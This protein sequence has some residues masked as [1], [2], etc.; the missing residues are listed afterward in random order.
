MRTPASRVHPVKATPETPAAELRVHT[1]TPTRWA[2]LLDCGTPIAAALALLLAGRGAAFPPPGPFALFAGLAA[3][4]EWV[5]IPLTYGGYQTFG[6]LVTLPLVVMLGPVPAALAAA[7]GNAIGSG[8]LRRRPAAMVAF[9]AGQRTLSILL[10]GCVW[11]TLLEGRPVFGRPALAPPGQSAL[12]AF[13]GIILT[14]ALATTVLVSTRVSVR[15][16]QPFWAVLCANAPWQGL[17]HLVLGASGLL[18]ALLALGRLHEADIVLPIPL[19]TGTFVLLLYMGR[20][21]VAQE[22]R[23]LHGAVADLLQTLDLAEVLNRLADRLQRLADP[24]LIWVA[25]RGPDGAYEIPLAR[26]IA[27]DALLPLAAGA[28]AEGADAWALEHRRPLRIADYERHARRRPEIRHVCG[29]G[30]VRAALIVPLLA[31]GEPLG[32]VTLTKGIPDFFTP[33]QERIVTTLAAQAALAVNNA[34]LYEAAQRNLARVEAVQ[35]LARIAASGEDLA[36]VQQTVIDLAVKVLGADRGVLAVYDEERRALTGAAFHNVP[37]EEAAAWRTAVPGDHWRTYA[38]ARAIREMQPVPIHDRRDLPGAPPELPPGA[39]RSVLAVPMSVQGRPLGTVAVGRTDLHTWTAPEIDLLQALASEGA[40]AI[41]NARLSRSTTEQLQRIWALEAISERINSQHD[42]HAVFELIAESAREVLG[43][44]RCGI[45]L[46]GEELGIVHTFARG[47]PDDYLRAVAERIRR[48]QSLANAVMRQRGPVVIPDAGGDPRTQQDWAGKIG[49]RTVATFPLI[50]RGSAIGI[51]ALYHDAV[52]PYGPDELALGAA[53]AN[54]AAIAVQNTRL[55]QEAE[56]RAH[57]LGL[58]NRIVT[59]VARLLRPEDLYET[60]VEEL[61]TTLGYPFVSLLVAEGDR[62]RVAAYRGYIDHEET[63]PYTRGVVGRVARTR[64]AVLVEDVSRDPDY[65]AADPRVTQEACVPIFQEGRLA[66]LLNIEVIEPTLTHADLDLLVTLAGEVRAAMRNAALFAEAQQ[67]RDELQALYECAQALGASLELSTVLQAM[68]SVTCRQ[69]GYD[70]GAILL[71]D[72]S[73]DLAV[74]ATHGAPAPAGR[75]PIGHGAEGRAAYEARPVLVADVSRD[76]PQPSL[77]QAPGATLAVPLFREGR[78][79]GVF[80]VGTTRPG[81]LGER[82]QRTLMMLA[83]Y[84]AVAIENARLYEQARHFAVTDGLTDLLNHRAFR[85]AL[86]QE[87]ERAKRYALPLALIMIEIDKFKRY[88]DTYGHLRGDEV[89]RL[90][91]RVLEKEHRKQV[92]VIARY[93]GDE[94]VLFL[95]HTAK[96]AAAEVAERIRR[97]VESTPYIVGSEVTSVTLSLGV[98]AYP[99]DGDTADTLVD[100]ADRRMYAAKVSGGNAVALTTS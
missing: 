62:L 10:S 100:A 99:E 3:A 36:A 18:M 69:F 34:R 78:V 32:T 74:H 6:A 94:F 63:L 38:S 11:A 83:S 91:A 95:P 2:W 17:T 47:L 86:D 4:A 20:R 28:L 97:A 57:Q 61:H 71:V 46:G 37:A 79:T 84:A 82:D 27:P 60:L 52:H 41:E 40:V 85:Q 5:A 98:A 55:L 93:G 56:R 23:A 44:D 22:S 42:L 77:P 1:R 76:L 70:R 65:V 53:F 19:L 45:Y 7:L 25:L 13:L 29:S 58:L 92:D 30:R 16:R 8:L 88:N 26:G 9:N 89:L 90:V 39:S 64:Q 14:Y 35:Q 68:V 15:R 72:P 67:A 50:F 24:D 49:Y 80:S 73:G 48:G 51:L 75:V 31:G 33:Y 81:A 59:R 21:Q 12:P 54:Q 43:A 66:G 87:L 96:A